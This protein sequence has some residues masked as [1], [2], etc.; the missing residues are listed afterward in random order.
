MMALLCVTAWAE[1]VTL[2]YSG[3]ETTNMTGNND[4]ALLG[5]DPETWEV[6]G[7]K[8]ASNMLPGLNNNGEIRLYGNADG[9]NEITVKLLNGSTINSIHISFADV[10][11]Y[12][13]VYVKVDGT[14]VTASNGEYQINSTSFVVGNANTSST[15]VRFNWIAIDYTAETA[16][17]A[18]P[19]ITLDPANGPYYE[20][21]SVK[22][23]ITCATDGALIYYARND[24]DWTL[25]NELTVTATTTIKARAVYL[26]QESAVASK[27]VTFV[28]P[29]TTV[30]SIA[31]FNALPDGTDV[32]FG[33]PVN[34]IKQKDD[35]LYVQDDSNGML[36]YGRV[37]GYVYSH[38][39]VVPATFRGKKTTYKGAPEF[40]PD[41]STFIAP[42]SSV[43]MTPVEL[44]PAQVNL[45][46]VFRY[47]VIRRATISDNKIVVGDESVAIYNGRF[48]TTLPTD[49]EGKFYDIAGVVG[50]YNGN[51]F[52]PMSID[53]SPA[54]KYTITV[55]PLE[56]GRVTPNVSEA[57][58]GTMIKLFVTPDYG[59]EL[60]E[61]TYAYDPSPNDASFP[62]EN[63]QFEMPASNVTITATFKLK[64]F[65]VTVAN[66]ITNGTVTIKDGKTKATMGETITLEVTAA[67]GYK[68]Q[69]ITATHPTGD[70]TGQGTIE[71]KL[72]NDGFYTFTMPGADVTVNAIFALKDYTISLADGIEHGTVT[73]EPA[74]GHMGQTINV[75]TTPDPAYELTS[76]EYE[77]TEDNGAPKRMAIENNQF[78][79][80][81]SDVKILA[82]FSAKVY[83][84]VTM[85]DP[86]DAGTI[87]APQSAA[88]ASEVEVTVAA[89]AG[90]QL[91]RLYYTYDAGGSVPDP[92]FEIKDGKFVMPGTDIT[93]VAQLEKKAFTIEVSPNIEHGTVT[94]DKTS[95]NMGETVTVTVTPDEGYQL[96][97]LFYMEDAGS[98]SAER[99]IQGNQFEM[100]AQNVV[101]VAEFELATYAINIP[102]VEHGTVVADPTEATMG[103]TVT[104]TVTPDENYELESIAVTTVDAQETEPSGAPR[105]AAENIELTKTG[106]NTYTFTM[107]ASNVNV[108]ATF[109]EEQVTAIGDIK[110]DN[111]DGLRYV[112]PMGQVSNR[113]F[114]GLNIVIDGNKTYKIIK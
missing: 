24:G 93:I 73:F 111:H 56:H 105:K 88:F 94:T 99:H 13:N 64:T 114:Q 23:K 91:S 37:G 113:P 71:P 1:T 11:N 15:Q 4:A 30:N 85:V 12:R 59:Y 68:L 7:S 42:N 69:S 18:T 40:I 72:N 102:E 32:I 35:Y 95:A 97:S 81:A 60:D 2:F 38:G 44:T 61:L 46:N 25:G 19:V 14:A 79:M 108:I 52:M 5:L 20:G 74:T 86:E 75:T 53:E 84:I 29:V 48:N 67:K 80:P 92:I 104:L 54:P 98:V 34:T 21:T 96:K 33:I 100:P 57:E 9:G 28:P 82:V 50:Y 112:N 106:D 87:T 66:D 65:N 10:S 39:D 31:Q 63:N 110:A 107:P 47:A 43:A 109:K 26:D 55:N 45:D 76:L 16:A 51:Q 83:N 101:L 49:T 62:I 8:G 70:G 90:Y 77:Y 103:Q 41:A 22:A 78:V 3:K 36:I 58:A 27:T 17:V 6:I 89:A